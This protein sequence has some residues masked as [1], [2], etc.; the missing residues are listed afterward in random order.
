MSLHRF[1][2]S[3]AL[4]SAAAVTAAI[5][6]ALGPLLAPA[7]MRS[8]AAMAV[9][10]GAPPA[11]VP[12]DPGDIH[13]A[14]RV[15]ASQDRL[16]YPLARVSRRLESERSIKIVAIGSSS[17]AGAGASSPEAAY[18]SRL[19]AEL[20][21]HFLWQD[22]TVLN[23]GTNGEEV[24]D[25]LAR[26]DTS[27]IAEKPDLVIWQMGTNSVLRDH[28][29][30]PKATLLHEGLARLKAIHADVILVDPQYAPKVVSKP[31]I[32]GMVAQISAIAKEQNVD[33]F[34]RFAMMRRWY[35]ADRM[36]FDA[37]VSPDGVHMNDWSYACL[38]KWL[39]TAIVEAATR[40]TA[41]ASRP[42]H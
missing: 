40:P 5:G 4:I 30:D 21:Q 34:R 35:Q 6:L 38:A 29:I 33:V 7:Q 24:G 18:P 19:E 42:V 17:T 3:I 2:R 32:D 26:F 15:L 36:P 13:P 9:L 12:G 27:V 39:G 41:T 16:D 11:P 37:F 25:M 14:C 22:I 10:P 23:R 8:V 28:P 20:T 31:E 1:P